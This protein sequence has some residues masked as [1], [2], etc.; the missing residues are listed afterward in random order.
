MRPCIA[1][2]AHIERWIFLLDGDSREP[3]F[4]TL[5]WSFR[6]FLRFLLDWEEGEL[7]SASFTANRSTYRLMGLL[8]E[9]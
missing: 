2:I 3:F 9:I 8:A 4:Q 1:L 7:L 6:R 5:I